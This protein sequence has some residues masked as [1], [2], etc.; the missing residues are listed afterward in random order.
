[1]ESARSASTQR[2][3]PRQRGG[4]G[5]DGAE[6]H[7][8][9]WQALGL[10]AVAVRPVAGLAAKQAARHPAAVR[11][12][13]NVPPTS[14]EQSQHTA[15][16]AGTF[17]AWDLPEGFRRRAMVKVGVARLCRHPAHK[18]Q[19]RSRGLTKSTSEILAQVTSF[20]WHQSAPLVATVLALG[21]PFQ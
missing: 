9:A 7:Q 14:T 21:E 10:T 15:T 11:A 6:A 16:A 3:L 12:A 17:A 8:H 1:M 19:H 4:K 13:S 5:S 20:V 18:H 2:C